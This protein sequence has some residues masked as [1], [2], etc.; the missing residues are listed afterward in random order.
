[1]NI[2]RC[3]AVSLL[4]LGTRCDRTDRT[5]LAILNRGLETEQAIH[6]RG[7]HLE[8]CGSQGTKEWAG[9]TIDGRRVVAAEVID[10]I[11]G[12]AKTAHVTG[13]LGGELSIVTTVQ[14]Y[15]FVER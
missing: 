2:A 11:D 13:G 3:A 12:F 9:L 1:M 4:A 14:D 10:E 7:H 8:A 6:V 15:D 5:S